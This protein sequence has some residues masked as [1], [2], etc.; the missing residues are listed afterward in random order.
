VS[1]KY[2]AKTPDKK[3]SPVWE[4]LF[5]VSLGNR[6][7]IFNLDISSSKYQFAKFKDLPLFSEWFPESYNFKDIPDFLLCKKLTRFS[8]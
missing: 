6:T 2:P 7:Q 4:R 3:A 8:H 5:D 1:I